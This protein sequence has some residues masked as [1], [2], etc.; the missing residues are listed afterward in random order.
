MD[1][2]MLL[3]SLALYPA[4]RESSERVRGAPLMTFVL[5]AAMVT[6]NKLNLYLSGAL[7]GAVFSVWHNL[8]GAVVAA[9]CRYVDGR[10]ANAEQT[11]EAK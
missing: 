8:S 10:A 3:I 5:A 7:P 9:I 2:A 1:G 4:F 11:G 6:V